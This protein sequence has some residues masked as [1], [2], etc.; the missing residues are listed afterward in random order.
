MKDF[1][2]LIPGLLQAHNK[3]MQ[4][5]TPLMGADMNAKVTDIVTR[6]NIVSCEVAALFKR[7]TVAAR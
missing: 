4:G 6:T 5:V 1:L 2:G 3:R 7:G